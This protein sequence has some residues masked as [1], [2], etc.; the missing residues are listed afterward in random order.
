MTTEEAA[1]ILRKMRSGAGPGQL[2]VQAF[3]FGLKYANDIEGLNYD[4][5]SRLAYDGRDPLKDRIRIG[6]QLA[7]LLN[8]K[9]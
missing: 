7:E 9:K 6:V 4:E 5:I 1:R 8:L 3:F 2:N